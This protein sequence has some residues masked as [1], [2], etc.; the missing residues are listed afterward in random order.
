[1]SKLKEIP[2]DLFNAK[3]L[4]LGVAPRSGVI[5]LRLQTRDYSVTEN[6]TPLEFEAALEKFRLVLEYARSSFAQP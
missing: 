6:F 4:A 5:T 3:G 1:M 2:V